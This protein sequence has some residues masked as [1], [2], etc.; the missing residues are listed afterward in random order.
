LYFNLAGNLNTY[1]E[2]ESTDLESGFVYTGIILD[3]QNCNNGYL[4]YVLTNMRTW[5]ISVSMVSDYRLD[6][7]VSIPGRG[8]G[9]FL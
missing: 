3:G 6:N 2:N 9:V 7:K 4:A 5:D 8:K 1:P